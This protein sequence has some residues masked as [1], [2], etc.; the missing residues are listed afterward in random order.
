MVII[1]SAIW[2][3]CLLIIKTLSRTDSSVPVTIW[4]VLLLAPMSLVPALFVWTWPS[5]PQLG[6]GLAIRLPGPAGPVV[7]THA[8]KVSETSVVIQLDF[9]KLIWAEMF[10]F[11]KLG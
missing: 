11:I 8:L 9:F 10:G 5:W 6:L 7:I 3:V 1:S 2:G 4:I